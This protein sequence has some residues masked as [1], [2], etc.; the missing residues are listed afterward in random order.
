MTYRAENGKLYVVIAAGGQ[1]RRGP[2]L[3]DY[4]VAFA[5]K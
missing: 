1:P 3:G 4:L 5:V 2:A